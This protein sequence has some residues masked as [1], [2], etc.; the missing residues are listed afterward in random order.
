MALEAALAMLAKSPAPKR[1]AKP[2]TTQLKLAG[3]ATV[4]TDEAIA[5]ADS[6]SEFKLSSD[7]PKNPVPPNNTTHTKTA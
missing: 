1:K 5:N 4:Q 3:I 2:R 7:N 6:A